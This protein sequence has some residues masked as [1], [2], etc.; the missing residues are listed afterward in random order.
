[1]TAVTMLLVFSLCVII[2]APIG[3]AM[4]LSSV[5]ALLTSGMGLSMVP[6]NYYASISKFLLL[7]IPFFILAGNIME[8]AGISTKLIAFAQSFVGHV[9]GGL[10][11]VC[12]LV[13]CFFAA[14]SGSGP[15]TVA[16]LGGI[17][18]P[19]MTAVGY[20]K[21]DASAL[22]ATAGGIGIIIPPSISFVVYS[23]IAN[24]S[25]GTLFM[26][27]IVPGLLMGFS[28]FAASMWVTRKS[29]LLR[30]PK[31]SAANRWAAFKDAFWGLMMPVIIL[32]GIY[33]GIFTPTEAAAVAAVYG[34]F[35]GMFIYRTLRM[36]EL[37]AIVVDS[38]KQTG[39]VMWTVGN[40]ALMSWVLSVSGISGALTDFVVR[41]SGGHTVIFLIVVNIVILIAGCFIDGNSIM[42]IFVPIFL[43]VALTLGY[44]PIVLGVVLV[45]NVAIGMVTPPVGCNLY[46]ACGVSGI[47]VKEI[48]KPVIPYIVA[49]II[50]LL[51]VT[52]IPQITLFLP[53]LLG[54][55]S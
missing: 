51:L 26:A 42:Y 6:F 11:L 13:A 29:R 3:T 27:G 31:A 2:G 55:I 37:L 19:A 23:S 24:V 28:L 8:K 38:G 39:A 44:N 4:C 43:P 21:G 54:Q 15:A 18:I 50:T 7:A 30:A 52:Y 20:S 32:G 33:G 12:V 53:R 9:N 36:K 25:V 34:L 46:V 41:I 48:V 45:M 49:S 35:V 47:Q 40:A 14:I 22:M 1:M 10:A 16:A 17:I 5:S